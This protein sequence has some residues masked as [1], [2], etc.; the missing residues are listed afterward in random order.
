[1]AVR[2]YDAGD[3]DALRRIHDAARLD[4]LRDAAVFRASPD[5]L[6][7]AWTGPIEG[8]LSDGRERVGL[9]AFLTLEQTY[10]NEELFADRVWVAEY[11][12]AVAGFIAA[13][14]DGGTSEITWLYVDPSLR[15]RGIARALVEHVLALT[16]ER[17]ELEVL[18]GNGARAFYERIGFTRVS[19]STGKLAGNESFRAVGHVMSR[20]GDTARTGDHGGD[21][22]T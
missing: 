16:A 9:D 17:C 8:D 22:R 2:D 11:E 21:P 10:E 15:R 1:M 12:D 6:A 19:T 13:G 18:E 4:E 14:F 5:E 7:A 3:W 20:R